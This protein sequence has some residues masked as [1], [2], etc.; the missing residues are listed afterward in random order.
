MLDL[1]LILFQVV[2]LS[3]SLGIIFFL[4]D[5]IL[6]VSRKFKV[7]NY[8]PKWGKITKARQSKHGHNQSFTPIRDK[9]SNNRHL[10]RQWNKLLKKV[11]SDT[12]TA[13]RLINH[14]K[15]KHPGR[16]DQWYIEKA[17]FDLQRDQG[18]Y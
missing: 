14:L 11:N 2:F 6:E 7:S 9:Y 13:E 5:K 17:I 8:L 16:S 3:V 18:R 12:A 1:I 10:S 4:I 15:Q